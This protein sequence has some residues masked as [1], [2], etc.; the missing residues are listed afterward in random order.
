MRGRS[1]G[2]MPVPPRGSMDWQGYGKCVGKDPALFDEL[3]CRPTLDDWKRVEHAQDEFCA[4]CS[5]RSE[6]LVFAM[7]NRES[8]VRGGHYVTDGR[9]CRPPSERQGKTVYTGKAVYAL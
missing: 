7:E 9:V 1:G 5:V 8:G 4:R 6:C 3:P 2:G